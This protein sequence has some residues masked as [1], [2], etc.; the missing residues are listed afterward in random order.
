MPRCRWRGARPS[1]SPEL[2]EAH[3]AS[4]YA[5]LGDLYVSLE[6]VDEARAEYAAGAARATRPRDRALFLFAQAQLAQA[7]GDAQAARRLLER[8]LELD[9]S[10]LPALALKRVLE[11]R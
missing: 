4:S 8:G 1:A 11:G 9:P 10:N 5:L 3:A 7:D 2:R 6:R